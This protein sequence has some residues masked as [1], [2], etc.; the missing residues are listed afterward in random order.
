MSQKKKKKKTKYKKNR[1][2]SKKKKSGGKKKVEKKTFLKKLFRT[3]ATAFLVFFILAMVILAVFLIFKDD[4]EPEIKV[5]EKARPKTVQKSAIPPVKQKVP[6]NIQSEFDPSKINMQEIYEEM[7][8]PKTIEETKNYLLSQ[9]TSDQLSKFYR[10]VLLYREEKFACM[11]TQLADEEDGRIITSAHL[12]SK[13]QDPK[14]LYYHVVNPMEMQRRSIGDYYYT[15]PT[16]QK[17]DGM[18]LFPGP[19]RVIEPFI[20]FDIG[21]PDMQGKGKIIPLKKETWATCLLDGKKYRVVGQVTESGGPGTRYVIVHYN[22]IPGNSGTGFIDEEN[23]LIILAGFMPMPQEVLNKLPVKVDHF[24]E[25]AVGLVYYRAENMK[26]H[27]PEEKRLQ[28]QELEKRS[29]AFFAEH[30]EKLLEQVMLA[31]WQIPSVNQRILDVQNLIK[32]RFGIKLDIQLNPFFHPQAKDILAGATIFNGRPIIAIYVPCWMDEYEDLKA[33]KGINADL[34]FETLVVS[35]FVHEM[36]HLAYEG[37]LD[38]HDLSVEK[39]IECEKKANAMT[40]EHLLT[41]MVN[42]NLPLEQVDYDNYQIWVM[43]GRDVNSP[44]WEARIRH[45]YANRR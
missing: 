24:I 28:S 23:N 42:N 39:L 40:C 10:T 35:S 31:Q 4:K 15:N 7:G 2:G 36:D 11:G 43:C 16:P 13:K 29:R 14:K 45:L 8:F 34:C 22:A 41:H 32:K 20:D 5:V 19:E 38:L 17:L 33:H 44:I 3:P 9:L 18:F 27:I 30:M 6:E 12:L 26:Q 25:L 21:R 1:P 37:F